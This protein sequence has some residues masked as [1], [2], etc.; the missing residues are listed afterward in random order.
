[1]IKKV[2]PRIEIDLAKLEHNAK[3]LK[4]FFENK[5]INIT[6][7]VKG[8]CS[9][10]EI[11]KRLVQC[12]IN[13]LADTKITNLKKLKEANIHA[14]LILL[15]TPSMSEISDT[16]QFADIS[17]N[18]ELEVVRALSKEATNQNKVHSIIVMVEM[19]DLREGILA[20]DVSSFIKEVLTFPNIRIVGIGTNFACFGGVIPTEEKMKEF[21]SIVERLENELSLKFQ[22]VSGGNSA[23]YLWATQVNNVGRINHLRL[24]ESI[25]LGKDTI[26]GL[27]IP[28]LYQNAFKFVAEVIESKWKPSVPFGKTAKNAFGETVTFQNRGIIQRA[29]VGVG[30]QDI[31]VS[32]L[33]PLIPVE[34]L[35]SSSDHIILDSKH[36]RLKPGDEVPFSVDYGAL[37]SAMTSPYVHKIFIDSNPSIHKDSYHNKTIA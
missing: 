10:I 24:G 7:V 33:T 28:G 22:Y 5:G 27:P 25:L 6:A 16:I 23:N 4:H 32:G 37:I 19:G 11:S 13:S 29:I 21:S 8:V 20:K 36:V 2:T 9:N 17:V 31:L 30:R 18:T 35:G 26:E 12:G 1:M 34:I 15:R 3:R 14:T